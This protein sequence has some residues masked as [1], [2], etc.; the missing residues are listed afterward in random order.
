MN[1]KSIRLCFIGNML[2]RN[3][4][5]ITTQG[6]VLADLFAADNYQVTCVSSK[7][8]RATRLW[9][10]A[11]TLVKDRRRFDVV[12]LETFSGMSFVIADVVGSLCRLF[13]IPLVMVLHGGNLPNFVQKYPRWSK[14]VLS[15]ADKLIAPSRFL[16]EKIGE[17]GYQIAV[18]PN[19]IDISQYTFRVR[20]KIAPKIVWM[21]SF[22]P[23][24]NPQMAIETLAALRQT[25]PE[26]TL[27]MAGVDKGLESEVK[28][29]ADER[30]LTSA[31]RF[32]GFLDAE[33]KI[34]EFSDADIYINT[35]RIDN[36]PVSVVEALAFGLP[37]VATAVGGVPYLI[38]HDENGLLVTDDNP[39]E[40]ADAIDK[41]LNDSE[42]TQKLSTNGR[43]LAE[44]SSWQAV[45]GCWEKL[46]VELTE[47]KS[48][49]KMREFSVSR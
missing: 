22:H 49:K 1:L 37:V 15:R 12:I 32:A 19:V 5:H 26:A 43:L 48:V 35:N 16:A 20:S 2:G 38:E 18:I 6:Q 23:I 10:I 28:N 33:K 17:K 4:N 39:A 25:M 9:E 14:R 30:G 21:R 11:A 29:L 46:F 3:A 7:I 31:V 41:L 8:N 40:M 47:R 45:R 24:Y 36:M 34:K 13:R 42:L 44:K 27:T